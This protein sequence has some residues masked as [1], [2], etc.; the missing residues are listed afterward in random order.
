MFKLDVSPTH[1]TFPHNISLFIEPIQA[2]FSLMSQILGLDSDKLVI[3]V[4]VGILC[5]VSQS[6]E[7]FCLNYD[8]F[9]VERISSQLENFHSSR[10]IFRYQ[11]L[12]MLIVINNNLQTLQQMEPEF[13]VD[14][15]NLSKKNTSMT[16]FN[17]TDKIMASMYKL[18]FGTTFPRLT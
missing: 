16:F 11:T 8:E 2:V 7:Q 9:F 18:I 15:A 12:V 14:N 13:F 1:A 6:K 5:L 10:K 17:F 3:E 4:M